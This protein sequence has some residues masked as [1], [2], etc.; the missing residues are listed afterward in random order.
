MLSLI[1]PFI[2]VFGWLTMEK[3]LLRK[4]VKHSLMSQTPNEELVQLRIN[5]KDT[6]RILKWKHSKEFEYKGEMYDI[7]RRSYTQSDVV[8]FVWWDNEET[9]LNQ[10]LDGLTAFLFDQ[11]PQK[12]RSSK[13][14]SFLFSLLFFEK[15]EINILPRILEKHKDVFVYHDLSSEI[16][17]NVITPPPLCISRSYQV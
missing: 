1:L 17:M 5:K 10:K 7:V 3:Q 2:G 6:L 4:E 12:K 16:Y 11:S 14:F 9:E 8:Y 13:Q 15:D